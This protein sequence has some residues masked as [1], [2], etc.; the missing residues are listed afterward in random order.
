MSAQPSAD[1]GDMAPIRFT[2]RFALAGYLAELGVPGLTLCDCPS[3]GKEVT[4]DGDRTCGAILGQLPPRQTDLPAVL[5]ALGSGQT[6]CAGPMMI[7][8]SL[9]AISPVWYLRPAAKSDLK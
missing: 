3:A 5:L 1:T 6:L 2:D 4:T 9:E 8:R 7:W